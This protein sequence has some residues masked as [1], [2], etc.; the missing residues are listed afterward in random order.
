MLAEPSWLLS[1]QHLNPGSQSRSP[2]Q[3]T[4]V[5]GAQPMP[6]HTS[7][8]PHAQ[9]VTCSRSSSFT[10]QVPPAGMQPEASEQHVVL[11]GQQPPVLEQPL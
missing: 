5:L 10:Q 6:Q 4:S 3:H 2:P 8:G 1:K 9:P 7:L 11:L